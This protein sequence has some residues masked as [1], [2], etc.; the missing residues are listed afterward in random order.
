MS[1]WKDFCRAI[2]DKKLQQHF[3]DLVPIID[4]CA[5][6]E[7]TDEQV[8]AA[9][10]HKPEDLTSE[11][12]PIPP[13]PFPSMAMVGP[14]GVIVLQSPTMDE[15]TGIL[16]FE[17]IT[18]SPVNNFFD[19]AT[20]V[21]DSTKLDDEGQFP[22]ELRN[23]RSLWNGAYWD[24][25]IPFNPVSPINRLDPDEMEAEIRAS[26]KKVEEQLAEAKRRG[27]PRLIRRAEEI[28]EQF[29]AQIPSGE[30]MI[31]RVRE[32]LDDVGLLEKSGIETQMREARDAFYLGLQKVNWINH[33]NH[34]IIE[35]GSRQPS[36]KKKKKSRIRRLKERNRHILLKKDEIKHRWQEAQEAKGGTHASPIPH[37]RRGHYK[38]LRAERFKEKRGKRI[39]TRASHVG[40]ECVEW[41][42]GDVR[43]KVL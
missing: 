8:T 5:L 1:V 30:R 10:M 38:T 42:D 40:G 43:Y 23:L 11:E 9:R 13:F 34:Y 25:E 37:L 31:E 21:V 39:W 4:Q 18:F 36:R 33:P 35:I 27:D 19:T 32:M 24:E 7:F 12:Y 28:A 15:E 3:G 22:M 20:A 14:G 26:K 6:F 41:R 16:E 29:Y 2:E 17:I